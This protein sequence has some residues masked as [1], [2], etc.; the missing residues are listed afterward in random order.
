MCVQ[1]IDR[2]RRD[3]SA[4]ERGRFEHRE[5]RTGDD[6][7]IRKAH[8]VAWLGHGCL[9]VRDTGARRLW[10]RGCRTD[11]RHPMYVRQRLQ[12]GAGLLAQGRRLRF[13][14]L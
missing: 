12:S 14:L 6:E 5:R 3:E 13:G 4:V 1:E 8:W 2:F 11:Q 7:Y 10:L 9:D